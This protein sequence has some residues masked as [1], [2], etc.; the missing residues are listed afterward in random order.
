MTQSSTEEAFK[1]QYR[2]LDD[3]SLRQIAAGEL[4]WADRGHFAWG[5][6]KAA[7]AVLL[8]RGADHI[9]H[10][11]L[12]DPGTRLP[13]SLR[14]VSVLAILIVAIGTMAAY[15]L[16]AASDEATDQEACDAVAATLATSDFA[17][18]HR[19]AFI[20]CDVAHDQARELHGE[21]LV[22][23]RMR[24]CIEITAEQLDRLRR[25]PNDARKAALNRYG[26]LRKPG[27]Y[28]SH[29]DVPLADLVLRP[30]RPWLTRVR[31]GYR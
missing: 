24:G 27:R 7:Q 14:A 31:V 8:E 19:L 21:R 26:G 6:R 11:P 18:H 13:V 1:A 17:F 5:A 20:T 9:P 29:G 12:W 30:G 3:D 15:A 23:V 4:P 16:S 10:V 28:C 25:R 22:P 2:E